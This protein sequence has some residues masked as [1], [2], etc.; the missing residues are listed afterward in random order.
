MPPPPPSSPPDLPP[1]S[2]AGEDAT[3]VAAVS[4]SLPT[5]SAFLVGYLVLHTLFRVHYYRNPLLRGKGPQPPAHVLGFLRLIW[6]MTDDQLEEWAGLDA[7]ALLLFLK[8]VL[9]VLGKYAAYTLTANLVTM[10]AHAHYGDGGVWEGPPGGLARI[11][12]ANLRAFDGDPWAAPW[13]RWLPAVTSVVGA[14]LLT[15]L[16]VSE[17]NRSWKRMLARRLA[18][19]TDARD[20]SSLTCLVRGGGLLGKT[21]AREEMLKLWT[22]LYPGAIHDIRIVRDTGELRH[23]LSAIAHAR[24]DILT[25]EQKIAKLRKKL[26]KAVDKKGDAKASAKL[27]S[28]DAGLAGLDPNPPPRPAGEKKKGGGRCDRRPLPAKLSSQRTELATLYRDLAAEHARVGGAENER[29]SSYFVLFR[30][31]RSSNIA[32]QVTNTGSSRMVVGPAPLSADVRWASLEPRAEKRLFVKKRISSAAFAAMLCFYLIPIQLVSAVL[33]LDELLLKFPALRP[34]IESMPDAAVAFLK[35]LLPTLALVL[36]LIFLPAVCTAFASHMGFES[37]GKMHRDA[38]SKLFLF[39]F[40]SVFLG[41]VRHAGSERAP[42]ALLPLPR[43]PSRAPHPPRSPSRAP[44][45][46]SPPRRAL[47]P[48][49]GLVGARARHQPAEDRLRPLLHPHHARRPARRLRRLLHGLPHAAAAGAHHGRADA[50]G[51]RH[52]VRAPRARRRPHRR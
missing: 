20:A 5:F 47:L 26:S 16:T 11:S 25:L 35:A 10:W 8:V 36:F 45:L 38:F 51:A 41:V 12:I 30:D 28:L 14:W 6:H 2:L 32:R 46:T 13:D 40:V 4:M 34:V 3:L 19:L 21:Y 18:S 22:L 37:I 1:G 52:Q 49:D 33:Q 17:L 7:F 42:T 44:L 43:S 29:G 24:Q 31:H 27:A 23:I 39:Q 50:R 48:D 9:R 15:Y